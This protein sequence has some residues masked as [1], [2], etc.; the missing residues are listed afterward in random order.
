MITSLIDVEQRLRQ[1]AFVQRGEQFQPGRQGGG[2]R[3]RHG[4]RDG[5]GDGGL[6]MVPGRAQVTER[7]VRFDEGQVVH[8]A[9]FALRQRGAQRPAGARAG[10]HLGRSAQ[11]GVQHTQVVEHGALHAD[12]AQLFALPRGLAEFQRRRVTV[13]ASISMTPRR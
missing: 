8:R 3:L 9:Q 13:A 10:Q 1:R 11:A 12:D 7:G 4:H 5:V 6:H 2:H